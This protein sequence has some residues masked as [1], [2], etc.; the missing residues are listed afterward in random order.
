MHQ[1]NF[2]FQKENALQKAIDTNRAI[3][4]QQFNMLIANHL[5]FFVLPKL[6]LYEKENF[7]RDLECI[8]NNIKMIKESHYSYE[9]DL[10]RKNKEL[11]II[12]KKLCVDYNTL[13]QESDA[14]KKSHSIQKTL[15][16]DD[17]NPQFMNKNSRKTDG[18]KLV[19]NFF[20]PN[21]K[22]I[23]NNFESTKIQ[24]LNEKIK[25]LTNDLSN[26]QNKLKY[27]M[28]KTEVLQKQ[29]T[30]L[31]G[32]I[33]K[34]EIKNPTNKQNF[35]VENKKQSQIRS[36]NYQI[37]TKQVN[38]KPGD[39]DKLIM[40]G[41]NQEIEC[42]N[43]KILKFQDQNN[44]LQKKNEEFSNL[45]KR[46]LDLERQN[47]E[48]QRKAYENP[49]EQIPQSLPL[50]K[51]KYEDLLKEITI[52][53]EE[54]QVFQQKFKENHLK[55]DLMNVEIK[56]LKAKNENFEK[57]IN[58]LEN[59]NFERKN[60]EIE[61]KTKG[62]EKKQVNF[63]R[64]NQES[65]NRNTKENNL[66]KSNFENFQNKNEIFTQE[67]QEIQ[68]NPEKQEKTELVIIKELEK[69]NFKL[70]EK[71]KNKKE[72]IRGLSQKHELEKE[73]LEKK[74]YFSKQKYKEQKA[75]AKDFEKK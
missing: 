75:V 18:F 74:C 13:K 27:E 37:I 52:L 64:Q 50:Y 1:N 72:K 16:K 47:I 2:V 58:L 17:L 34:E 35:N 25:S 39:D 46:N 60:Q 67:I 22:E 8:I 53:R 69:E 44:K 63:V 23:E 45:E 30:I 21:Q 48:L 19:N 59:E 62:F 36:N 42:L 3:L 61:T 24:Q 6:H 28:D 65:Q 56:N 20:D 43:N 70:K 49:K 10:I 73:K 11:N 29:N 32:K 33:K 15:E 38:Q 4:N 54:K 55:I 57:K 71:V 14:L 7:N 41:L 26:Y 12:N 66:R 9:K 5:K 68:E 40:D 31:E 51:N